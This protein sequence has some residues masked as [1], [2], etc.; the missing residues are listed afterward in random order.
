MCDEAI[1]IM[2]RQSSKCSVLVHCETIPLELWRDG[3]FRQPSAFPLLRPLLRYLQQRR[4]HNNQRLP[5]CHICHN[6]K[7]RTWPRTINLLH[8]LESARGHCSTCAFI[9]NAILACVSEA[10]L[11]RIVGTAPGLSNRDLVI[12]WIS[13]KLIED[14]GSSNRIYISL[15]ASKGEISYLLLASN[16]AIFCLAK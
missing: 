5:V 16:S 4:G 7:T 11:P 14:D 12:S 9:K 1:L 13:L 10:E 6:L 15:F 8:V 3:A 2:I